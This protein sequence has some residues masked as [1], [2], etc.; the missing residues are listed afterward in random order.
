MARERGHV[1]PLAVGLS[2]LATSSCGS[3][4]AEQ[5]AAVA[6]V[7]II[8]T[9]PALNCQNL[10]AVSGSFN[11]DGARGVRAKAVLLGGNTVVVDA[12]AVTTAFYC[13]PVPAR[14]P[15]P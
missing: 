13:P 12:H 4:T 5:R 11:S 8:T 7:Q 14:L 10:G 1:A 2:L 15:A 9:E 6:K 3:L